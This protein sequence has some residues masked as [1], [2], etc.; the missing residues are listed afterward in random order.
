MMYFKGLGVPQDNT[1]ALALFNL[2]GAV[3]GDLANRNAIAVRLSPAALEK[4]QQLTAKMQAMG[5]SKARDA[6]LKK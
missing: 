2:A 5:V 3:K 1:I 6:H 4:T